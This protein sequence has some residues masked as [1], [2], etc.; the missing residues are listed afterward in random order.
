VE[1]PAAFG[2]S[3]ETHNSTAAWRLGPT[4]HVRSFPQVDG[5]AQ[6]LATVTA[7]G[8][9]GHGE[10][11]GERR[12][13]SL[14]RAPRSLG[15]SPPGVGTCVASDLLP[16]ASSS[17]DRRDARTSH[18]STEALDGAD[19]AAARPVPEHRRTAWP[20]ASAF[21]GA[22]RQPGAEPPGRRAGRGGTAPPARWSKGGGP[23]SLSPPP[24]PCAAPP[25]RAAASPRSL[26]RKESP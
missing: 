10:T 4:C 12:T 21:G 6:P 23:C 26:R 11:R 15:S 24:R 19:V 14:G 5:Q 20:R 16:G 8:F 9:R 22:G 3:L 2:E 7:H 18:G 25:A 13:R 1:N 17:S